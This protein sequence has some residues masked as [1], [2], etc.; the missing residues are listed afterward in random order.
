MVCP[1]AINSTHSCKRDGQR[2]ICGYDH[3]VIRILCKRKRLCTGS[4]SVTTE[5]SIN[6]TLFSFQAYIQLLR[7]E[8]RLSH[9]VIPALAKS[10]QQPV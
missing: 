7:Y 8:L 6:P 10:P 2:N 3:N 5:K 9:L 1:E 4:V